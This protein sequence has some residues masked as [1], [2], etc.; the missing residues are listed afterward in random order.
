MRL[1]LFVISCAVAC[2]GSDATQ[3]VFPQELVGNASKPALYPVKRHQRIGQEIFRKSKKTYIKKEKQITD[4]E[5]LAAE[6]LLSLCRSEISQQNDSLKHDGREVIGARCLFLSSVR[7][8]VILRQFQGRIRDEAIILGMNIER[9][10][11]RLLALEDKEK[12][13]AQN[14]E[15]VRKEAMNNYLNLRRTQKKSKLQQSEKPN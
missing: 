7:D 8:M 6:Q 10:K 15:M 2:F 9:C 1:K 5:T 11:Q 13:L 12:R 3:P 14:I 4:E